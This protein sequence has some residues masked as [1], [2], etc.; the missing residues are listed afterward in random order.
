MDLNEVIKAKSFLKGQAVDT[1]MLDLS[2]SKVQPFISNALET[3]IKLELFQHVGSFKSRG[4]LLAI[5]ALSEEQRRSGVIAFS[6]GNHALAV[7]WASKSSG[8][9]AK[10]IMPKTADPF[11]ISGCVAHGAEILL[12]EDAEAGFALMEQLAE[13]ENR[14]ILHPFESDYMILGAATCG[15]EMIEAMPEMDIAI[16]PIGG[17]GL[18][19]GIS[20]AIKLVKPSVQVFGVEPYGADSMFQSFLEKRPMKVKKVNTIADSLGAPMALPKSY[21]LAIKNVESVVR[22]SEKEMI[23][24]MN[25]IREKLNLMV[26]P[27]CASSL[28]AFNGPLAEGVKNKRVALIAC[29]SNISF[30]KYNKLISSEL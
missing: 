27:A 4:V 19:S 26:E 1:P 24:A 23:E 12:A 20:A 11:R 10:V 7:S 8:I 16:I 17:G 22:L 21:N 2:G 29:G 6:A 28:A 9:S 14:Q 25:F 18:I 13:K 3:R 5:A 15:L 30:E